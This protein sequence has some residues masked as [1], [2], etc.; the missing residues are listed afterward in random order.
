MTTPRVILASHSS[1]LYGAERSL[2]TLRQ[3]VVTLHAAIRLEV[4]RAT[5]ERFEMD[6]HWWQYTPEMAQNELGYEHR[7]FDEGLEQTVSW[8]RSSGLIG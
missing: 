2:L 5:R 3:G 1:R 4:Y 8:M 6:L 7:A